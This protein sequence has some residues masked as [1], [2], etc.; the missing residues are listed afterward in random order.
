MLTLGLET[1]DQ[2][3]ADGFDDLLADNFAEVET[4][5]DVSP[6]DVNWPAYYGLARSGILKC[7]ALR[8]G[9]ALVGYNLFFLQPTLHSR[10][11]VWAVNDLVYLIPEERRGWAGVRLI[12][13]TE[14]LLREA[15]AKVILYGSKPDLSSKRHRDS[16]GKLFARLGYGVF[17]HNWSKA[18]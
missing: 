9:G 6:L 17:D 15:G 18:L 12:R 3:R 11:T 14:Q 4:H 1:L 7:F 2:L 8:R 5:Q 16:V 13:G 10:R